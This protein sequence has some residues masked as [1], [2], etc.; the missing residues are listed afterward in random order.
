MQSGEVET[1]VVSANPLDVVARQDAAADEL[2]G[3]LDDAHVVV[4]VAASAFLRRELA[5]CN[6]AAMA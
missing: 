6:G 5:Q 4:E 2:A 1:T 3:I